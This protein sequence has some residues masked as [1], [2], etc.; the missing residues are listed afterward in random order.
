[1][2][3]FTYGLDDSDFVLVKKS[4]WVGGIREATVHQGSI[5]AG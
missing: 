4:R 1:M 5:L 2:P 3:F